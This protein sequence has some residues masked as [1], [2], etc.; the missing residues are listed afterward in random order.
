M[1]TSP[2]APVKPHFERYVAIGDSTTEGLDDRVVGGR[3]LGW[4]D[5][6]ATRL[7]DINPGLLYANLAI[8]GRKIPQIRSEQLEPALALEPDLLSVIGG[9]NDILRP[10]VEIEEI[11]GDLEAI[12]AAGREAGATVLMA[13]YPDLSQTISLGSSRFGP[14]ITGYNALVRAIAERQSAVLIDLENGDVSHPH[15][16]A[17]DRLHASELG[18]ERIAD[19]AAEALGMHEIPADWID[20]LPV[21]RYRSRPVRIAG[22]VVW[23]GRYLAPWIGRRIRGTS[24]GDGIV[25]KRPS[26]EPVLAPGDAG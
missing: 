7:A 14:R 8:R 1:P 16:W 18:H 17:V 6:L 26:L 11:A 12:A 5:R 4:A 24:S 15:L 19:V 25:P 9:V 10:S 22:D 13:T 21:P 3:H 2:N 23:F 20:Q